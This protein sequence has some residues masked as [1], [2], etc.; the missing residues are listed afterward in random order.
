MRCIVLCCLPLQ[1]TT[2]EIKLNVAKV[3]YKLSVALGLNL[4]WYGSMEWNMEETFSMEWKIFSVDWKWNG[5][6]LPVW[7]VE[8]SSSIPYHALLG[9]VSIYSFI[10]IALE[11]WWST[12]AKKKKTAIIS[13]LYVAFYDSMYVRHQNFVE[14][15]VPKVKFF[16]RKMSYVDDVH[17]K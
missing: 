10:A 3:Q 6:K 8:K 7:S 16:V 17:A 4:P 5:R 12:G 13:P 9:T 2:C 14:D 15:L 1:T 11:Q